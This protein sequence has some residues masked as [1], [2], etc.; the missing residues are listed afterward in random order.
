MTDLSSV[1]LVLLAVCLGV[2]WGFCS[3]ALWTLWKSFYD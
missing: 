1:E 2:A 3:R